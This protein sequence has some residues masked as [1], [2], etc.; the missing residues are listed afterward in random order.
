MGHRWQRYTHPYGTENVFS[1]EDLR[2]R[3]AYKID[4]Y[5]LVVGH[6]PY[7]DHNKFYM[8]YNAPDCSVYSEYHSNAKQSS[9]S[10]SFVG[11]ISLGGLYAIALY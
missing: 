8:S 3:K 6:D 9:Y 1:P 10:S 11:K 2:C 4:S 5:V 7:H